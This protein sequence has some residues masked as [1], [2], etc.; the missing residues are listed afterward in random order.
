M[1]HPLNKK[2][3]PIFFV[4]ISILLL[5]LFVSANTSIYTRGVW[6]INDSTTVTYEIETAYWE[7]GIGDRS[8]GSDGANFGNVKVD[9]TNTFDVEVDSIDEN[10]GVEFTV[11]N[12]TASASGLISTDLFLYELAEFLYYPQQE[13]LKLSMQGFNAQ[14]FEHGPQMISWFFVEPEESL[15]AYLAELTNLDYHQT[16]ENNYE[17][18]AYF[19]GDF[20]IRD[21]QALFDAYMYG[22]FANETLAVDMDFNHNIKFVWDSLTGVLLGY[23]ISTIFSGTV[24]GL[25]IGESVEI[26]CSKAGYTLPGFKFYNYSGIISGYEITIAV[27]GISAIVI[28]SFIVNKKKK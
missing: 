1:N 28:T 11:D 27:I 13:V 15:W 2:S 3:Q 4:I 22:S 14:E 16:K 5:S 19:E 12:S 7:I 21:D 6:E 23:R 26:I 10:F 25:N 20:E 8:I 24:D 9:P 18:K 17:Y